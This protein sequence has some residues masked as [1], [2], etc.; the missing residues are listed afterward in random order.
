MSIDRVLSSTT[1]AETKAN[2]GLRMGQSWAVDA[3]Q[4]VSEFHDSVAQ[5][6][7]ELVM[8][9]CSAQ[10]DLDALADEMS[11]QFTGVQ[12]VGCTTAGEIGPAGCRDASISGVSFSVGSLCAVTGRLANL[13]QFEFAQAQSLTQGML[14]QLEGRRTEANAGNSFAILLIDGLSVREEPVAGALQDLLGEVPMVGGSAGDGARFHR[15]FVFIDGRFH[16]DSAVLVLASTRLPFRT[17]KT[18]HFVPTDDRVVVTVADAAHRIVSE[19]DGRPA[20]EAYADLIGVEVEELVP[21]LFASEPMVVMIDGTNYVRSIQT[22]NMDGSLTFFSSIEEGLVLRAARGIDL[23]DSLEKAFAEI[24]I[25]IGELQ[26][27][28]CFDCILRRLEYSHSELLAG[29]EQVFHDN[30]VVG[31]NSYGEQF[32]GVHVNQTLTGLAFG[33][34]SGV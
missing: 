11:S 26:L 12:V 24:Q 19:I 9:F 22:A 18:Q 34:G 7:T 23:V 6:D 31:F 33:A 3:R 32:N 25:A 28:V 10:Y 29:V 2:P 14:Q 1:G 15:T 21:M 4:A 27:V 13:Q 20:A 8:F 16:A 30:H 5:P 17:F